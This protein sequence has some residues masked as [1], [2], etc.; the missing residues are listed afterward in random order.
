M[1]I[2]LKSKRDRRSLPSQTCPSK[3]EERSRK[4]WIGVAWFVFALC[5]LQSPSALAMDPGYAYP[6][7]Q[8]RQATPGAGN[9]DQQTS[10]SPA[11]S[12]STPASEDQ[13]SL[14]TKPSAEDLESLNKQLFE[15]IND[16]NYKLTRNLIQAQA[17]VNAWTKETIRPDFPSGLITPLGL[18]A[19][20]NAKEIC[21][22]LIA[23]KAD[24][25]LEDNDG[26]TALWQT[27]NPYILELLINAG[28]NLDHQVK[29]NGFT[30][31][32][33]A[34][35][36]NRPEKCQLLLNAKANPNLKTN[37][38]D[39][40]LMWAAGMNFPRI[41]ELLI[42]AKADVYISDEHG[43]TALMGNLEYGTRFDTNTVNNSIQTIR[44]ILGVT[45]RLNEAEKRS[46]MNW[47]LIYNRLLRQ[48]IGFNTDLKKYIARLIQRSLAQDLYDNAIRAGA[49]QTLAVAQEKNIPEIMAPLEAHLNIH[50]LERMVR[51]QTWPSALK[52]KQGI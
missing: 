3:L 19:K 49:A 8:A 9:N 34:A 6:G 30:Q 48:K 21:K 11:H 15:A 39:T 52:N 41:C 16:S 44:S 45:A 37:N 4:A 1:K 26:Y 33:R 50:E 38:G 13:A 43:D 40:A 23:A 31:L 5:A 12:D 51:Q 25:N 42:D 17:D 29:K 20:L 28:A 27:I 2:N 22:L 10:P 36:C 32:I 35:K 47:F 7:F 14:P 18:A 24:V 46:V